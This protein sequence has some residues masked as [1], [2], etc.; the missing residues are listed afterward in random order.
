MSDRAGWAFG[1]G[2]ERLAMVLFDVPDIRLFWSEDERLT[3]QFKDGQIAKFKP[4]S[5]F[6]A[7]YKDIS[8]WYDEDFHENDFCEVVRGVAGDLVEDVKLIDEF[9]H[10]KT[11]RK[12]KC[13]RINYQSMDR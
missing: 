9:T 2:I 11:K 13:Y 4:F 12:S 7:C 1:I 5:K 8:F 3:S 6:P 10:P